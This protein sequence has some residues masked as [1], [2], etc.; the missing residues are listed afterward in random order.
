TRAPDGKASAATSESR[1]SVKKGLSSQRNRLTRLRLSPCGQP[2]LHGQSPASRT[3]AH[4]ETTSSDTRTDTGTWHIGANSVTSKTSA[5]IADSLRE[6]HPAHQ[7]LEAWIRA[8]AIHS[9]IGP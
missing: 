1:V 7:V 8:Q 2:A 4:H 5:E 9:E 3:T 6:I